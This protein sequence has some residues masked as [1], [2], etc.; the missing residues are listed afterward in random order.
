MAEWSQPRERAEWTHPRRAAKEIISYLS[1]VETV[2]DQYAQDDH[3]YGGADDDDDDDDVGREQLMDNILEEL[4]HQTASIMEDRQGSVVAEKMAR[5]LSPLQLRTMLSRCRGY[6]L[7]LANN[8]YS[9]HVLQTLLSVAGQV[10]E[11]EIS[12]DDDADEEGDTQ[13]Y[14]EEPGTAA[15]SDGSK[16]IDKM[17]DILLALV[18]E[19]S[20]AWAEL[21]ADISGSH[22]GRGFLQVLGGM[23]ILSEK[24][25]RQSRHAHSI[26]TAVGPARMGGRGNNN[27]S[28]GSS[29]GAKGK[30]SATPSVDSEALEKW[31][32]PYKHRVPRSFVAALGEITS[33]LEALPASE[34]QTLACGTFGCPLLVMLLRVH[35]NLATATR[36]DNPGSSSAAETMVL[37]CLKHESMA[38]KIVKKVLEWDD[39]ER[40]AQVVYAISGENTASHF[41][42]AVLWLSPRSFFEELYHRCFES[43][44]LEF[45]EHGVSNFLIQA[46][47]QRA[48]DKALAEKMVE[49][50]SDNASELLKARRAGVLWR[51]AQACVRLRLKPKTQAKI[52]QDIALAVQAG[53]TGSALPPPPTGESNPKAVQD[54]QAEASDSPPSIADAFK[55]ARAWVPALLSPRLP[56]EGGLDRLFLNVP[57]ARIV[58]NALLFDPP[59]AAPV[60]K[61][62][63]ALP[64]DVLAAVARDNMGSRCLLD[65]ILEAAGARGGGG[66]K[67]GAKNKPAEEARRAI[68]RAFKGHLV[69]MACDRVAWHILVKC[70]RGVD[71]KEKRRDKNRT[72][73]IHIVGSIRQQSSAGAIAEELAGGGE[74]SWSRMSGYPSGRSVLTECMVERFS[75]SPHEWED[76]FKTRDNRAKILTEILAVEST[77]TTSTKKGTSGKSSGGSASASASSNGEAGRLVPSPFT[78]KAE[79]GE[80]GGKGKE[81][82]RRQRGRGRRGKSSAGAGAPAD[83]DGGGDDGEGGGAPEPKET[84]ASVKDSK[85]L[86]ETQKEGGA[87]AE[88]GSA[89]DG[90]ATSEKK[91]GKAKQGGGV[92]EGGGDSTAN[93]EISK[94]KKRKRQE[95][96]PG[97]DGTEAAGDTAAA[98]RGGEKEKG[99]DL[100]FVM[101]T[102]KKSVSAG[103]KQAPPSPTATK[104]RNKK[105]KKSE[106]SI[107]VGDDVTSEASGAGEKTPAT[108]KE[109][110]S[111]G[112]ERLADTGKGKSKKKSKK[113][114]KTSEEEHFKWKAVETPA[115]RRKDDDAAAVAVEIEAR[116]RKSRKS[117]FRLF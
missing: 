14:E 93:Q 78:S 13:H 8:R 33:E 87:Q 31:S 89:V 83:A 50:I 63:A 23:P 56:G 17:Q 3:S 85:R 5:R 41:L 95:G 19:L 36:E 45:C 12:G 40:S 57:G 59:V 116:G 68:L 28:N 6:M 111:T 58:Q 99:A 67:G 79:D 24:R 10:V 113:K 43:N 4:K 26:G 82:R 42:E 21:F 55:A 61:A 117:G 16:K 46:A 92:V 20:G 11:D 103:D 90:A 53:H 97:C 75:R 101:D 102:I 73:Q 66:G 100:S 88:E 54:K 9:S 105:I 109:G 39:E 74:Q 65:P 48:D 81:K 51:A 1:Q 25:G 44:L 38:M 34:L 70:F 104:K 80:D 72:V 60:L 112:G 29:V 37:P 94:K 49:A 7:S 27:H 76:A 106:A 35:G 96:A 114:S 69:A 15:V 110:G 2:I 98:A 86:K 107:D 62:V 91:K 22:V 77:S 64:D 47:L 32:T 30:A 108:A 84:V 18:S 71:M 52:L 115:K